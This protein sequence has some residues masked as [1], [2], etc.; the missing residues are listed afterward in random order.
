MENTI[1]LTEKQ[2]NELLTKSA[3]YDALYQRVSDKSQQLDEEGNDEGLDI[4]GEMLLSE[5]GYL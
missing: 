2:Y 4:F 5:F 3:K 1:Q